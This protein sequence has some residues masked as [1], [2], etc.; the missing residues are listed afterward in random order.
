[1]MHTLLHTSNVLDRATSP[2]ADF[3]HAGR[4]VSPMT[5]TSDDTRYAAVLARDAAMD[6]TFFYGVRTTGVFCMPSCG[7]RPPKRENV[8]FHASANDAITAGFRA[9]KRCRPG[10]VRSTLHADVITAVCRT[11][12]DAVATDHP[13]PTLAALSARAGYSAFHLHRMFRKAT[14]LTPREYAVAAR[15]ARLRSALIERRTI[16]EAIHG[17]GYSSTSRFYEQSTQRLGMTPSRA[18]Q[19][20]VGETVRFAVGD[21]SLGPILV[22]ATDKGVCAIQFGDDPEA[23]VHALERRFSR[24]TL[25]GDDPAFSA[26]VAQVVAFVNAPRGTLELPLDIRGTAFQERVWQALIAIAPGRTVSYTELA[27]A[28]GQPSA[29]RAVASA[30]AAN[31]LAIAIPC[32][33]V[34]R[35]TGEISGYRWG[36]ERKAAL[37]TREEAS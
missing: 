16:S 34:V 3:P 26:T 17:A 13:A 5:D 9:C 8:S 7:A 6:G 36:V 10:E 15:A 22:A 12:D 21:S 1:M 2:H 14:G 20:G 28:I 27:R 19:G 23:L 32:H 4:V 35:A 29:V 25:I 31:E 24:A 18:R 11:I 30:C 33:R 37:L